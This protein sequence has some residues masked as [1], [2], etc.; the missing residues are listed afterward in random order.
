MST[1]NLTTAVVKKNTR[2]GLLDALK[3]LANIDADFNGENGEEYLWDNA[4]ESGYESN[5]DYLINDIKDIKDDEELINEYI[6]RWIGGDSYYLQSDLSIMKDDDE[7][8][9]AIALAVMS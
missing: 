3:E 8:I 9:V 1:L 7:K 2:Q 4:R 5:A 6:D